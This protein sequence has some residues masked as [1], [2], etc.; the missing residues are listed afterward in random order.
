MQRFLHRAAVRVGGC[1]LIRY[2]RALSDRSRICEILSVRRQDSGI[3]RYDWLVC[4]IWDSVLGKYWDY[5]ILSVAPC[6][7][8]P[9]FQ[10][11]WR[12]TP[13]NSNITTT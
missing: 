12:H 8:I 10:T 3:V 1:A 2:T 5:S 11:A 6:S 7:L 13:E 4:E 9:T